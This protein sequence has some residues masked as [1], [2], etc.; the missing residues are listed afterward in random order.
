MQVAVAIPATT[1]AATI[2][3]KNSICS[4]AATLPAAASALIAAPHIYDMADNKRAKS[5]AVIC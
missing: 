3:K 2:A 1:A 4:P 5:A